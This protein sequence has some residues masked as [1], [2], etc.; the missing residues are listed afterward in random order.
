M[1][2][3]KYS[4]VALLPEYSEC[5]SR[6]DCDTSIE[7]GGKKF[8]L[9]IIPANMK[10]VM[11]II[12][13]RWMSE[14]DYFYIMHRFGNLTLS[15]I[16]LANTENWKTVSFSVG[17][18]EE[19]H[20][21]IL[22]MKKGGGLDNLRIDFLTIDIAHGHSL[23]MK[24][25]I[26]RIKECLPDTTIIAGNVATPNA[27]ADLSAWGADIVKVGVGQGSPCTTK[28]KTGFTVPMFS[29]VKKCSNVSFNLENGFMIS[30]ASTQTDFDLPKKIPVIADGG[31]RHNGDIAKA[32]CAG[33]TMVM[34]GGMFAACVDSPAES[35]SIKDVLHK[36]YFGSA[37]IENKGYIKNIEGKSTDLPS[38]NM[39][40]KEKFK[41]IEQDLQSSISYS[42]GNNLLSLD[43]IEYIEL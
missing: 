20:S 18:K 30:E 33:A 35:K 19:D 28:D 14:N 22:Q 1:K 23:E 36:T 3:L 2:Y 42:G 12:L 27:V 38:N 8:K 39:T 31:V 6:S 43:N 26:E 34:A 40:Y 15:D 10:S 29:C 13:A 7:L 37:S 9:P 11:D 5:V 17:V 24:R 41:E 25:M 32:L 21:L 4:D 16:C